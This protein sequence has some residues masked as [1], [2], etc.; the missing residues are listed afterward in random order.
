MYL[1]FR[2]FHNYRLCINF[3]VAVFCLDNKVSKHAK[4]FVS[5]CVLKFKVKE[6]LY[7]AF[8]FLWKCIT[9]ALF[10]DFSFPVSHSFILC[11]NSEENVWKLCDH[12]KSKSITDLK[13][14]YAVFISNKNRQVF[15]SSFHEWQQHMCKEDCWMLI[16][17]NTSN[18]IYI[19]LC[20]LIL[21]PFSV[22]WVF[23]SLISK[24]ME[25]NFWTHD[26]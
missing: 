21:F 13:K 15:L 25:H 20:V 8:G 6:L 12:V 4:V 16:L 22:T 17:V 23:N 18:I 24:S 5:L 26:I 11:V 7:S 14:C 1:F 2:A 3:S 19:E 10:T 9:R